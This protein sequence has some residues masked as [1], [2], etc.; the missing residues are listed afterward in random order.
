M[1]LLLSRCP[2]DVLNY[3]LQRNNSSSQVLL[4]RHRSTLHPKCFGPG[5]EMAENFG[6][7]TI[8]NQKITKIIE[9]F[10]LK[11]GNFASSKVS[12]QPKNRLT[13]FSTFSY[14]S[15]LVILYIEAVGSE[16][17]VGLNRC[18]NPPPR[19]LLNIAREVN[20]RWLKTCGNTSCGICLM[21]HPDYACVE[22]SVAGLNAFN[23]FLS[24]TVCPILTFSWASSL[25]GTH[26]KGS[27]AKASRFWP[28]NFALDRYGID[29]KVHCPE[30]RYFNNKSL[31]S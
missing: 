21:L 12:F 24:V 26:W 1:A 19:N 5:D 13:A 6:E 22:S 8:P 11:F 29:V 7:N 18:N 27:M 31:S 17:W 23:R 3:F 28:S 9:N 2:L 30:R 10:F 4:W 15:D 16:K 25:V 20:S 14:I